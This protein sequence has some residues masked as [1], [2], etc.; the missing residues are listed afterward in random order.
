MATQLVKDSRRGDA[1]SLIMMG[2]PPRVVIG[3]PSPN[4]AEVQKE[5]GELSLSHGGTDLLAT[6]EAIDRVLDV[7]SI[8]RKRSSS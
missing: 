8:P 6:F 7:S 2:D 3:D 1:I 4:L 5:I